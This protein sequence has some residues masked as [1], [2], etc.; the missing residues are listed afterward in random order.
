MTQNEMSLE[1]YFLV[2]RDRSRLIAIIFA[3]CVALAGFVTYVTPKMYTASILLNFDFT[4]TNPVD[5]KGRALT[6]ATY[7]T[8]QVGILKS[9][10]VGQRVEDSLSEYER[11]RLISALQAQN[12]IINNAITSIQSAFAAIA[13]V[14]SSHEDGDNNANS[15]AGGE[16][17]DVRSIYGW[18][19]EMVGANLVVD[20]QFNSRIVKLSYKSTGPRIAAMMVDRFANAYLAANLQMIIDPARKTTVWF[21]EQ[22]KLLRKQLE[23]AQAE[24][25]IY[26]Q[27]SGIVS[28][29]ERLDTENSRLQELSGR[30]IQAQQETREAVTGQQKLKEI[31]DSG[32]S[33]LT[34]EAVFSNPVVQN[35]KTEIRSLQARIVEISSTLGK[36]HPTYK[37]INSELLA[38]RSRLA[39]EIKAIADG[40]GNRVEVAKTKERELSEALAQQ[41]KLVLSLKFERDRIALLKR[42]L[43]SA[44]TTYNAALNQKNTTSMQSMIDQPNVSIVDYASIP[45]HHSSPRTIKNLFV[46]AF[47][48]LLL[49]IG[50]VVLIEIF[51]RRVHSKDDLL[52]EFGVPLLGSLTKSGQ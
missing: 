40:I 43:E 14:F 16:T 2:I 34:F 9:K 47:A 10:N 19:A 17:L 3:S 26:Q 23:D 52:I 41:K 22:L 35:V 30:L 27:E 21:D 12:S 24:L 20:P 25:T 39:K 37:R 49:G 5:N 46:G 6:Q 31:V 45:Q 51:V 7:I 33:L 36:N 32:K 44:Q 4:G 50:S 13:G 8:T 18:L 42:G 11:K 28:S 29:D 1:K 48:G 15:T 38:A